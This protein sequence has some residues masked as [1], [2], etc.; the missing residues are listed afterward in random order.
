MRTSRPTPYRHH[1]RLVR[2]GAFILLAALALTAIHFLIDTT[3]PE[4]RS[5]WVYTLGSYET[6]L[7]L[8]IIGLA[9]VLREPP[10]G[11]D[12]SR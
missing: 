8:V 10:G 5:L 3:A 9:L 4:Q 7:I 11:T 12:G 2:L 1:Y 6:A